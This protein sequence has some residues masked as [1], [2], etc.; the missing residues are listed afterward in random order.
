MAVSRFLQTNSVRLVITMSVLVFGLGATALIYAHSHSAAT[1]PRPVQRYEA[2]IYPNITSWGQL[3]GLSSLVVIGVTGA[4]QPADPQFQGHHLFKEDWTQTPVGIERVLVNTGGAVPPTV[5]ILQMGKPSTPDAPV[6][7]DFPIL[8]A[9]TR[10]LLFL[11]PSPI[12]GQ[13]YPVGAP[14]GVFTIAAS[15]LANMYSDQGIQIHDAV[16]DQIVATIQAAAPEAT[17]P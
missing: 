8:S 14:Q 16:L 11:T 7:S 5:S 9:G 1:G 13:W 10:Y 2:S 15:G 4:P 17:A 3:K 12:P 6:I